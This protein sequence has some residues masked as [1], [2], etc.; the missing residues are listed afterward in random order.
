MTDPAQAM[1]LAGPGP[2][3]YYTDLAVVFHRLPLLQGFNWLLTGL[4]CNYLP[5]E[6]RPA[7]EPK[8]I[9]GQLLFNLAA[10]ECDSLQFMWAVL[11]GFSPAVVVDPCNLALEPYADGNPTYWGGSPAIQ[12][13][14]AEI[15]LVCWDS[16]CFLLLAQSPAIASAFATAFPQAQSLRQRFPAV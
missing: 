13:P 4:E 1:I 9:S 11:S 15:E 6:L 7:G 10:R 2:M 12:Y 14:G 8:W 5:L 3:R 16:S